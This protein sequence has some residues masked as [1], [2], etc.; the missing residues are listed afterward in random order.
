LIGATGSSGTGGAYVF[1]PF[2][3]ADF[4]EDGNVDDTDLAFWQAGYGTSIGAGLMDG[5]ADE[6]GDVDGA[7]FLTWQREFTGPS[8]LP[9][10]SQVP[11]PSSLLLATTL[12]FV[13]TRREYRNLFCSSAATK[14]E[15]LILR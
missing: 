12:L 8:A 13:I 5:D 1:A 4:N 11:E 7:D 14:H 2:S 10:L 15:Y 9:S 6:D 3:A